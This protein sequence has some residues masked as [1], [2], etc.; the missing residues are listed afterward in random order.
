MT[1]QDGTLS[2]ITVGLIAIVALAAVLLRWLYPMNQTTTNLAA[3]LTPQPLTG[4]VLT[5]AHTNQLT[6]AFQPALLLS[7]Q[8][9]G[10]VVQNQANLEWRAANQPA[11]SLVQQLNLPQQVMQAPWLFSNAEQRVVILRRQAE[12]QQYYQVMIFSST[13]QSQQQFNL[14]AVTQQ[15]SQVDMALINNNL[16]IAEQTNNAITLSKVNLQGQ[17]QNQVMMKKQLLNLGQLIRVINNADS[18]VFVFSQVNNQLF[19]T[20]I[21]TD[22]LEQVLQVKIKLPDST[23]QITDITK[24]NNYFVCLAQLANT[25]NSWMLLPFST[26]FQNYFTPVSLKQIN[27]SATTQPRLYS[28]AK[29]LAVIYSGA[30]PTEYH[31]DTYLTESLF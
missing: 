16:L 2:K 12:Q 3:T 14:P 20:K 13:W 31:V 29:S 22:N 25:P 19:I 7:E 21:N 8:A 26:D 15:P 4:T 27:A 24:L 30:A 6:A 28:A 1:E 5:P 11:Q 17:L 9:T 18:S 23:L 10:L